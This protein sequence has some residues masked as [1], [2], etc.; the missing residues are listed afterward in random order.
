MI[1]SSEQG[2]LRKQSTAELVAEPSEQVSRLVRDELRLAQLELREKG[3]R[4]ALGAGLA[5]T[6]APITS[7]LET[8]RAARCDV[9]TR[10]ARDDCRDARAGQRI[11]ELSDGAR[12]P[13]QSRR[14][15]WWSWPNSARMKPG[16]SLL[17]AWSAPRSVS[18]S[19]LRPAWLGSR[20]IHRRTQLMESL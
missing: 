14:R 17:S 11:A 12:P 19:G 9:A 4:A 20:S 13:A 7:E 16:T 18:L 6:A 3:K 10:L 15:S 2:E 1:K 8:L 5:D